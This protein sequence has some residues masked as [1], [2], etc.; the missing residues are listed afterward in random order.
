MKLLRGIVIPA[1]LLMLVGCSMDQTIVLEHPSEAKPGDQMSVSLVNNYV[2]LT[3]GTAVMAPVSRDSIHAAVGTPEGWSVEAISFYVADQFDIANLAA[4]AGENMDSIEFAEMLVDSVSA[5]RA[6]AQAMPE[7]AGM[8]DALAGRVVAAHGP[9][10]DDSIDVHTDSVELW[11]TYSAAVGISLDA[12]DPV[13]TFVVADSLDTS[14][15][16]SADTVGM[17]IIPVFIYV[18]VKAAAAEDSVVLYYYTKTAGMPD[19]VVDSSDMTALIDQGD[20]AYVNVAV[21]SAAGVASRTVPGRAGLL[22]RAMPD[23]F[24]A[25]TVISF[26]S[27]ER[28]ARMDIYSVEGALVKSLAIDAGQSAVTWN[29]TDN[30]GATV[31]AGT[32]LARFRGAREPE[33]VRIRFLP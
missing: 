31:T 29:G 19:T 30:A 13:D 15:T 21:S 7:D 5:Y 8:A 22:V 1:A 28:A 4:S 23:P 12:G 32:Y 9:S 18:Q 14:I 20:M 26:P 6:R 10:G 25:Q 24:T 3:S 16:I 11:H 17:T 27:F 33:A 2:Y